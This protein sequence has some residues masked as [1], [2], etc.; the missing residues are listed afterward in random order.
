V[1]DYPIVDAHVHL[2]DPARFSYAWMKDA[3]SLNRRVLPEDFARAADPVKIDRFVFVEVDVDQP[4]HLAEAEW[5]TDL[6]RSDPRI[7]GMVASLRL[8]RGKAIE[9]ELERLRRNK[10]LRGIRRLIQAETDP[11]F[12][13]RPGFI[14][15]LKLLTAHDL[16]FDI[17]I[18]HHQLPSVIAMVRQCPDLRFVLDHIGKPAIKQGLLDPWR[19]HMSELARFSNVHCKI[20]GVVTEADHKSW[21]REELKPYIAQAIESFGFDRV[22]YGGDWHVLELAGT[23]PDWVDIVDWVV[24][25]ASADEKRKLFRDNAISFYRLDGAA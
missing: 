22:M 6:A 19:R 14:E 11:D 18:L 3:P 4:Q 20:S 1:P 12:C 10:L 25:G 7:A 21:T 23:Y 8:E 2:C 13:I 5:V 16:S 15:G 24:E 17:C 9:G